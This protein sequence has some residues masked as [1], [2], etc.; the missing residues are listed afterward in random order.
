MPACNNINCVCENN[1]CGSLLSSSLNSAT[2]DNL[3]CNETKIGS[4]VPDIN[5][6]INQISDKLIFVVQEKKTLEPECIMKN[7]KNGVICTTVKWNDGT[8]TTVKVS[9]SDS[10]APSTYMAFCAALAKKMYG[11]NAKVH[12]TVERHTLEYINAQKAK[13]EN[14]KKIKQQEDEHRIHHRKVLAA[15]KRMKIKEE[16]KKYMKTHEFECCCEND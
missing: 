8:Y 14:E 1:V 16:A 4:T 13:A 2:A 7:N 9:E 5:S 6:R 3:T 15:A 10:C 11:T 12:R